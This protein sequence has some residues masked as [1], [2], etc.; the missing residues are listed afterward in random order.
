MIYLDNAATS[1]NRPQEVIDAVVKAMTTMGNSGR[2]THEDAL[3]SSRIIFKARRSVAALFNCQAPDLVCFTHNS[4]EALNIVINGLFSSGDHVISTDLEHNSVLRP[5]Y[6]L[7]K[8][9]NVEVEFVKADSNGQLDYSEFESLIKPNTRAIITTHASNLTGDLVD[10]DRVGKIAE[11]HG[12]L[13]IVDA[14]QTA[15]ARIIDI[16]KSNI[17]ILCFTGHK[18]L[19]GPQGTGGIVFRK[20]VEIRPWNVGGTGIQTYSE[21]QPAI[22]PTLLEAGTLNGHGIA[23]L[24]ASLEWINN[25]G[26]DVIHDHEMELTERFT[27][28]VKQ[29]EGIKVYGSCSSDKAPVVAL[30]IRDIDSGVISAELARTYGIETRSGGH[31]A[32]RIHRA[33]GTEKQGAVRFS[34]GWFNTKKD[35]DTAI[36]VL[37]SITH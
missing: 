34:F 17:D 22:F 35:V 9:R 20:S 16:E 24:L 33:L 26:I 14:S 21:E 13:Y 29:I 8:E 6:R 1:L 15:G 19:M 12:L 36:E 18:A 7:R 27:S 31:C 2:S 25:T 3:T 10:V 4:T 5:L 37:K 11:K 32:P 23:G 30:N 28:A